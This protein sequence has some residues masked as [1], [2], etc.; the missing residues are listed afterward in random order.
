MARR[1]TT[2][3]TREKLRDLR[4]GESVTITGTIYTARDAAH[5]RLVELARA[6]KPLPFDIRDATIYYVG[7][8]PARPGTSIG[9][10]G[11]TTSYRMDAYSPTLIAL[12]E[13]GMIGKGKRGPEVVEAMKQHGAVYF[14]AIGG[15]GALL[16]RCVKKA[17]IVAYE[18]LG[19][20]AVRRLEVEE[21]PVVVVI[22]SQGRSLYETGRRDYLEHRREE[23]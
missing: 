2:P 23:P 9:S 12:G 22:D 21:L 8:T 20:E 5:K 10:A 17:E 4:C 19:A 14:G 7:P 15:A 11:P 13:T 1:L 3:L 18:D 6:G 16:A